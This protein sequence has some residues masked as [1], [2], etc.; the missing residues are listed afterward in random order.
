MDELIKLRPRTVEIWTM[1]IMPHRDDKGDPVIVK[2]DP[3]K[4]VASAFKGIP[5]VGLNLP[6]IETMTGADEIIMMHPDTFSMLQGNPD[7]YEMVSGMYSIPV[8]D[9]AYR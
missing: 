3:K 4:L 1:E 9:D 6:Q 7:F 8:F 5:I 2:M